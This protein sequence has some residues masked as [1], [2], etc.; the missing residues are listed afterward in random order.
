MSPSNPL[1]SHGGIL[2]V[3]DDPDVLFAITQDLEAAGY[4]VTTA[5]TGRDGLRLA[6]EAAPFLMLLDL[7]LPDMDGFEVCRLAKADP[8]LAGMLVILVSGTMTDSER[9]AEALMQGADACLARPMDDRELLAQI[10][11]MERIWQVES[12]WRESREELPKLS[13]AIEQSTATILMTDR[14]GRIEYVNPYFTRLTGYTLEEV[15]GKNPRILKSGAQPPEFYRVLWSTLQSGQDWRGE[16]CNAKKSGEL[17]WESATI[18]P[19][20]NE[21]GEITHFVA[22]KEDITERKRVAEELQRAKEAAE[23]ANARLEE[24]VRT[25][26]RELAGAKGRLAI[27]DKAKSDFLMLISHELRTPL[28]GLFGITDLVFMEC[29]SNPDLAQLRQPF[30][31]S[32]Q[33]LLTIIDD[34]LLLCRIEVEGDKFVPQPI[35]LDSVLAVALEDAGVFAARR[36]VSFDPMPGC[37]SMI[38]GEENVLRKAFQALLETAVKFCER[39]SRVRLSI[40]TAPLETCLAIEASGRKIPP[41]VLARFFDVLAIGE[42][43]TPGGD[44]G[45]VPA[46]AERI[47]S[48]FGGSVAVENLTPPG[49]RLQIVLKTAVVRIGV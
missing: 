23:A 5:A 48:L 20:K 19:I 43:I 24:T 46:V 16:F 25:R 31:E 12:A 44:L 2:I 27:L 21:E 17:Y 49:I 45:L 32:R 3:D 15:R 39:G 34:A 29:E 1:N 30:E 6:K 18:S 9:R 26:T 37:A 10:R 40:S 13:R 35:A 4:R 42:A 41:Q 8:A 11:A 38:V 28:A 33:R 14:D 47:I 7:W 36:G 22:V